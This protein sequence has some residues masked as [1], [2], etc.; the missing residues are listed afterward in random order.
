MIAKSKDNNNKTKRTEI[1]ICAVN[2]GIGRKSEL[3]GIKDFFIRM[4]QIGCPRWNIMQA[5][6]NHRLLLILATLI[7]GAGI[8]GYIIHVT[9]LTLSGMSILSSTY[10]RDMYLGAQLNWDC[11]SRLQKHFSPLIRIHSLSFTDASGQFVDGNQAVAVKQ[12]GNSANA[13]EIE[14]LQDDGRTL[15]ELVNSRFSDWQLS[16][17]RPATDKWTTLPLQGHFFYR[18]NYTGTA[19]LREYTGPYTLELVYSVLG[20]RRTLK[21]TTEL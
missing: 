10:Q 20:L 21:H 2:I 5:R 19:A 15:I 18:V 1:L 8:Y 6:S 9:K 7:I 12:Q 11:S 3:Y 4:S 16:V 14:A 17:N 13:L